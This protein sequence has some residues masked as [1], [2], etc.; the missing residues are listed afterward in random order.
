M[1]IPR[2][3][4]S[5]RPHYAQA[6]TWYRYASRLRRSACP[7]YNPHLT[8]EDALRHSLGLRTRGLVFPAQ[9]ELGPDCEAGL[10]RLRA[11][12]EPGGLRYPELVARPV[13]ADGDDPTSDE[14]HLFLETPDRTSSRNRRWLVGRLPH[15][16]ALWAVPLLRLETDAYGTGPVLRFYAERTL[17]RPGSITGAEVHVVAAHAHE[18]ARHWLDWADDRRAWAE[19]HAVAEESPYAYRAS[20]LDGLLYGTDLYGVRHNAADRSDPDEGLDW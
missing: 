14:V 20:Y 13:V 8:K 11:W 6:R 3:T 5:S 9:L 12:T 16:D 10:L 18:A 17:F 1:I 4:T 7:S 19:S 15:R 2:T